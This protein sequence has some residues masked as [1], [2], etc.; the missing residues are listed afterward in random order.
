MTTDTKATREAWLRAAID[1]FRPRFIEVGYELPEQIRISVGFGSTGARQEN[2]KVL[3]VTYA[4][5]CTE[6]KVNEV[7]ISPEDADTASMLETVLHELIHVTLDCEDGHK[8]RFAEIATRLGFNGPMT[9]TPP[10][11]E[12]KA[13]LFTIAATLGEYPG[14]AMILPARVPAG[15]PVPV[16]PDG[17]PITIHSGPGTQTTRML[18]V[19][20]QHPHCDANGYTV[21]MTRK[22]LD[23]YGAPICPGS[24]VTGAT[25]K[26]HRLSA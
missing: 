19:S 20:C 2:A 4:R 15:Q 25:V 23:T 10:S 22:W 13:E 18:K 14:S 24:E 11:V 7:F 26:P 1:I 8:G 3:G 16:G 12:L 5:C 6:D 21:R 17:R 9:S